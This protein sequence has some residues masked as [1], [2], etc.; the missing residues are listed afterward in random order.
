M[1]KVPVKITIKLNIH[2]IQEE[3]GRNLCQRKVKEKNDLL[4]KRH[5]TVNIYLISLGHLQ[6]MHETQES[7]IFFTGVYVLMANPKNI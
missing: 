5:D 2:L 4:R 7:T 3:N 6:F 1:L